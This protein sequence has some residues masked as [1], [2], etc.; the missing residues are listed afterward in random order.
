[1]RWKKPSSCVL[2]DLS[3]L[4][5]SETACWLD[6]RFVCF[7][8][9]RALLTLLTELRKVVRPAF[10]GLCN[11]Q[12]QPK[13]G[14][15]GTYPF[16]IISSSLLL[17]SDGFLILSIALMIPSISAICQSVPKCGNWVLRTC[18]QGL[19]LLGIAIQRSNGILNALS[20]Q[21]EARKR[22]LDLLRQLGCLLKPRVQHLD[23]CARLLV[24]GLP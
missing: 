5:R 2:P 17:I 12:H 21:F 1:M 13:I 14:W 4:L 7:I 15:T 11:N 24:G 18:S 22:S 3:S 20:A 10:S 23:L 9:W 16:R 19:K 6:R 8:S